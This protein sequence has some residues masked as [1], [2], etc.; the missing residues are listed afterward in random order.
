MITLVVVEVFDS[1]GSN[2][3][4]SRCLRV[5]SVALRRWPPAWSARRRRQGLPAK[6][7]GRP[8]TEHPACRIARQFVE[9]FVEVGEVIR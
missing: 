1:V 7:E 6:A 5:A 4:I 9:P 3:G 8:P 2:V